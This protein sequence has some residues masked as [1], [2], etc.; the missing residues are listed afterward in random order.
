MKS[1]K[2]FNATY[3]FLIGSGLIATGILMLIGR[4]N[5]Y[6][7]VVNLFIIALFFLAVK[8]L[9]NYFIGKEKDRKINFIK[10]TI[11]IVFC[12]VFS[13]FKNIPLSIMPITFGF[14]L[15]LSGIIKFIN[16]GIYFYNKAKGYVTEF[17]FGI[18]Y[19]VVSLAIIFSPIKNIDNVLIILGIYILLL[20]INYIVDFISFIMPIHF[21]NEVRRHIRISLPALVE[22]IIPYTVL[23]EINYLIDKDSYDNFVFEEKK[24][25]VEPDMEVFVHTSK[26]GFNRTGHVDL[27]YNGKVLSYGSYDDSSLRFFDMIGDGV[28]FTT[29]RDKYIPFC[30]E[31]SKKTI[32][33][34][35][36][37]L[38]DRQKNQIDKAI[39]NIFKE[40]GEWK[41]PYQVALDDSKKRKLK[42][43]VNQN[44]YT[45]YASCLYQATHA[46]F[47]KF[48][49]GKW[50]K[51][52]VVGNN[53]C[54]LADYI[55]GK[56]GI[57]LLKMYGVITP[58]AYYEYLNREF[59]KKNSMVISRKIY[60]STNV[61]KKTIK[62]IF[63][64][65]S[66]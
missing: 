52:F 60:N 57:D 10:S 55:V 4:R 46:K 32:F 3:S 25:D 66:K 64:G 35:G 26:R 36:L 34:F 21:K 47:Y 53:C 65:F 43:K 30:I 18:I 51:Y 40:L 61:D 8:Q 22:A 27:Y 63:R 49:K 11:N 62:E 41:S 15:L 39:D 48:N 6:V 9:I 29:K 42:R 38:T 7:N 20:G 56:S 45:D 2:F 54:R 37:K 14:Y 23:S 13:L 59:K 12:F 24:N 16:G 1:D 31:H 5:L 44:K 50:K 19:L 28:V 17:F 33:A 58:G